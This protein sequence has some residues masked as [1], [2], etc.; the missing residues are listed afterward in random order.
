MKKLGTIL[1]VLLFGSALS[2]SAC[3][4]DEKKE[5][6]EAKAGDKDKGGGDKD[7][8]ADKDKGGGGDMPSTG[9]AECDELIK[10]TLCMYDKMGD[11]G[12]DARKAFETGIAG[13]QEA[14]KNDATKQATIDGCKLG[15]DNSKTA[16]EGQG[17]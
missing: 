1:T 3:K 17:C 11:A 6:G 16:L 4:K 14:A 12:K 5:G 13:W 10:R 15:L 2:L 8:G 9:L 7:K